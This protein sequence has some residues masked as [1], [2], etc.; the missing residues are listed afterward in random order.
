MPCMFKADGGRT[1][2]T[3]VENE[4]SDNGYDRLESDKLVTEYNP[5]DESQIGEVL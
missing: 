3:A 2:V 5:L 1:D 4:A